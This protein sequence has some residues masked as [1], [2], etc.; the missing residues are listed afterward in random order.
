MKL[1]IISD[2]NWKKNCNIFMLRLS[3]LYLYHLKI[4]N[5]TIF[6]LF[7]CLFVW[8][9]SSHS[10]IFH[11]Y[12]DVT[13]TSEGLQI[14]TYARHSWPLSIEGSSTCH[15]LCNTGHPFI[16]VIS[17]DPW[18]FNLLPSVWQWSCDYL[19]LQL[20]SVAAG[21]RSPN[22]PLARRPLLPAASLPRWSIF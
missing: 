11:S 10:R 7:V 9:F 14:L 15:T 1:R 18:L 5:N 3:S 4:V 17:E 20:M 16:M 21:I 19:C 6:I 2:S 22:L 13:I 8:S 12:G